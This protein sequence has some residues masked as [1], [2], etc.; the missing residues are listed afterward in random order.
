MALE[1]PLESWLIGEGREAD[2]LLVEHSA[3]ISTRLDELDQLLDNPPP[4]P[5][6]LDFYKS[7][8]AAYP[9]MPPIRLSPNDLSH[10]QELYRRVATSKGSG[11]NSTQEGL[12]YLIGSNADPATLPFWLEMLELAPP[13]DQFGRKRKTYALA[14][15]AFIAIKHDLSLAYDALISLT[16]HSDPDIRAQAT[17]YL[18]DAYLEAERPIPEPV[19]THIYDIATEDASFLPRYEARRVLRDADLSVPLDNPDGTYVFKVSPTWLRGVHRTMELRS[20]HTLEDLHL[21]IQ[22][23]FRWDDDHLYSFYL[24][25]VLHDSRYEIPHPALLEHAGAF[26]FFALPIELVGGLEGADDKVKQVLA[27]LGLLPQPTDQGEEESGGAMEGDSKA[28]LMSINAVIGE[29]G[30][31]PGHAFLYL[32]DFGDSNVFLVTVEDIK[33]KAGKGTYP[34]VVDKQ[35][36]APPQYSYWDEEEP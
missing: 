17:L 36:K 25:G 6:K 4:P 34:R 15:I 18:G 33:E 12:L 32:F 27:G 28:P 8:I 30:L 9:Y 29:L 22:R 3:A 2:W 21:T 7:A 20:Y 13:R 24:N 23:A 35:G 14:S 11:K 1:D 31:V 10:A 26:P 16:R 19:L 5:R